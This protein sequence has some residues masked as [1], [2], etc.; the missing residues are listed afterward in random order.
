MKITRAAWQTADRR[1]PMP[2]QAVA[3]ARGSRPCG[4]VA[5]DM[6]PSAGE[7]SHGAS[8]I[9]H[10][11]HRYARGA[12]PF[13]HQPQDIS[14]QAAPRLFLLAAH[15]SAVTPM[16]TLGGAGRQVPGRAPAPEAVD[17]TR[18]SGCSTMPRANS[19]SIAGRIRASDHH[20]GAD[21]FG[22]R[23]RIEHHVHMKFAAVLA[24]HGKN[25][26][27]CHGHRP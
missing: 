25:H 11:G 3:P 27:V 7:I 19:A 26:V 21:T 9:T 24:T 8:Q 20:D 22:G 14:C 12:E 16:R 6:A 15:R 4:D 23:H 10:A 17:K 1:P 13:R 18:T 2:S 5:T